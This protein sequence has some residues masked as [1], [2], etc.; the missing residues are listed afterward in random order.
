MKIEFFRQANLNDVDVIVR[1]VNSAY[2]PAPDTSSWTD[3]SRFVF[4]SRT[5]EKS[6]KN[7]LGKD[8]SIVLL[9]INNSTIMACAHIEKSQHEAHI[10][11]L[12][13]DPAC[14]SAGVGKQ[15]LAQAEV[16]AKEVFKADKFVLMVISL[17]DE[18]VDFYRRRGYHITDFT[19]DYALLCGE[20]C[21]AKIDGLKLAVLE[22]SA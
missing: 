8:D 22:K 18:L 16:Y 17:R 5:S 19:V 14:Q 7:L 21:D 12:A 11:M 2:H 10:G 6:V 13:V 3:E 4:G 15:M 1:L 20:T 9:G